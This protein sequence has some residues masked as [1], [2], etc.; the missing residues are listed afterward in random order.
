MEPLPIQ[1]VSNSCTSL[2]NSPA[3][4]HSTRLSISNVYSAC[5]S[6]TLQLPRGW[7]QPMT[8]LDIPI[9]H[10]QRVST[11][12]QSAGPQSFTSALSTME[13]APL[14]WSLLM[15][16]SWLH[17]QLAASNTAVATRVPQ[18]AR[19]IY[20][21]SCTS[22]AQLHLPLHNIMR[23][24]AICGRKHV[25][26]FH[27]NGRVCDLTWKFQIRLG[28]NLKQVWMISDLTRSL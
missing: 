20:P 9:L 24:F 27:S 1:T 21:T 10:L 17:L 16:G 3:Q 22:T 7:T 2:A 28:L 11:I 26:C 19:S 25:V 13:D 18:L 14:N 12:H 23:C 6:G 5:C 4:L 15:Q 8:S